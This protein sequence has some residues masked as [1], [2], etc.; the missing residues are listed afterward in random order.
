MTF[1][2]LLSA[3]VVGW[4]PGAMWF[5]LPFGDRDRRAALPA[6][7]RF[8][9]TI[10]LS[11]ATSIALVLAM[12]AAHR[13]SFKRLLIA[14]LAL[15]GALAVVSRFDLRLGRTARR[16]GFG[17]LLPL[18][19]LLISVWRFWPPFEYIIGGKDPGVYVNE[20][21]QIA[22]RGALVLRDPAVAAV[23]DFARP[24]FMPSDRPADAY[25]APR[26]MGF[27][28]LDPDRGLVVG[29]FPHAFPASIAIGYA[30]DGLTG[31]R[32]AI[33]FWGAL[34]VLSVY[35]L[36]A[37]LLGRPAATAAAFLLS[38]N[39]VQVWFA[40]YPNT[41]IVMQALLFA[42]M[43][44][45]A[46]AHV[47]ENPFFAP[48]AGALLGLLL[49]LRLDAVVA[50][51]A[52][53]GGLALGYAVGQR[54]R[55]TFWPPLA[56]AAA[57]ALWYYRGPMWAYVE[58]PLLFLGRVALW[59][60]GT[61][62]ALGA[63]VLA[64]LIAGRRSAAMRQRVLDGLPV[65]L[66]V[67]GVVLAVYA[68]LWREPGGK[69]TDYDAHAL[70]TFANF[71]LTVPAL[72]AALL[73]YALVA[74]TLFWRDPAFIAT[75]TAFSLFFFYK[76]RI[77]PDH[78]WMARR[79]IP[80]ILPGALLLIGAAALTGVRGRLLLTRA[81]RGPIG[82]VFLAL[83][84]VNYARA[85]KPIVE[86]VEYEGVIPRL[87]ALAARVQ[88]DDL[89]VVESRNA[90][91]DVHVLA[92]PLAY[93]YARNVLVLA[94]PAPDKTIFAAF[95]DRMH[96]RYRRVLFLGGGGTD[97]LSS[98]WSVEPIASERFQV[99]E[100]D[101]P[102]DA[103][104]RF[105]RQKEFEYSVYAFAPPRADT[106]PSDEID[107]GVN[108]DLNV[109]RFHAKEESA[110][111]TFRWSQGQSFLILNRLPASSRTLALWMQDGGRPAGAPPADVTVLIGERTLG[112]VRVSGD[113]R[114][115]DLPIPPDVAAA[116]GNGEPVRV[117]L[118][119]PTWNPARALGRADDRDLGV[120][121]DRV[122]VR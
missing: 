72:L 4:L 114:E 20:G 16:P 115:Y 98:K 64:L 10:V 96:G 67:V 61:L 37:R 121:V 122:A 112:T 119:V 107:I 53:V 62:A 83:L 34:G 14:E 70:R 39:V 18:A 9:W 32:A 17:V 120:M 52:V 105:A 2:A 36:G 7:E 80:V 116:A 86:H 15:A 24:L 11:A 42:A 63:V 92:L 65:L 33:V 91:S 48:V 46:R 68:F 27:Y 51:G 13:Y 97:L 118:R 84:A 87:E 76:I 79:F 54:V 19:L 109:L 66:T 8:Y 47:D 30:L 25:L 49:F 28:V 21:I 93:T 59:Q 95:L 78:F 113:F 38:L 104:P 3:C 12:A 41:D 117:T 99:P 29:Q 89:L 100:Y 40:R 102:R 50:V 45:S 5:R 111:R 77:W 44:A 1:L 110:G 106:G 90:G 69:L 82:I 57:L 103:Y 94:T 85:S 31:A 81:V 35:F 60:F 56:V 108:D 75:L 71:Y 6:D 58:V 55:W 88:D 74:R 101:A 73:G 26:F 22:Q 23:P 43:L